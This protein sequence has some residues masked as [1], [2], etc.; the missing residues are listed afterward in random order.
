MPPEPAKRLFC[1][2]ETRR[3]YSRDAGVSSTI[4]KGS[5]LMGRIVTCGFDDVACQV[6]EIQREFSTASRCSRYHR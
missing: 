5:P 6:S 3:R 1:F 2:Q 4:Q